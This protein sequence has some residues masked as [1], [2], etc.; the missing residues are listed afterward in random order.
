MAIFS[1]NMPIY[2]DSYLHEVRG[3][4]FAKELF[5]LH[6]FKNIYLATGRSEEEF[7]NM[8]WIKKVVGKEPPF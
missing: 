6:G 8:Y 7:D 5:D 2:I 1:K 4:Y 3:E